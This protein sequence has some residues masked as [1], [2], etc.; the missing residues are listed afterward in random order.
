MAESKDE[1]ENIS[2]LDGLMIKLSRLVN[3]FK[4]ES[5]SKE[6]AHVSTHA[7]G[8]NWA[9]MINPGR[10]VH[11]ADEGSTVE[12]QDLSNHKLSEEQLNKLYTDDPDG[13]ITTSPS[14]KQIRYFQL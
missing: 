12:L 13:V 7:S 1:P 10:A 4:P 5:A 2:C 6:Y 14:G 8:L 3:K 9:A 11:T